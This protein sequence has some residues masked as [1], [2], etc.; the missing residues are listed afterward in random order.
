MELFLRYRNDLLTKLPG[1]MNLQFVRSRSKLGCVGL[2]A[3]VRCILSNLPG[4]EA[5]GISAADRRPIDPPPI[6][7]LRVVDPTRRASSGNNTD[8]STAESS[9]S[10]SDPEAEHAY[11]QSYLQNPYYFMFA[12]LAKPDDEAELH[13]LKD[14]RTRCTTGSVVSSLYHLRDPQNQNADAG[15]FVFPDLSVRT[16]GSYRLKLSLFEVVGSSVRHC[17]SI[18]SSPFYVYTAK[19]FPGM[20][21]EHSFPSVDSLFR[22]SWICR[23]NCALVCSSRPGHQDSHPQR[24]PCQKET[25]Q[26]TRTQYSILTRNA[27]VSSA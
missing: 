8:D 10:Y 7:Q 1:S 14:G 22:S 11:S 17:K 27:F 2:V 5:N 3:K 12:C 21:G 24:Y 6:V 23:V 13:W 16:E 18:F 19:K 9:P 15:F 25:D 4:S 26:C 20:E